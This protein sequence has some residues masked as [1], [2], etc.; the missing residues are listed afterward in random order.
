M[1]T[2]NMTHAATMGL[3]SSAREITRQIV[4]T[5]HS[6]TPGGGVR[7]LEAQVRITEAGLFTF[8][9][10]LSADIARLRVP[11]EQPHGGSPVDGIT[12]RTDGLWRHT[13]F[14][15]F[16]GLGATAQYVE[17]N[18][19]PARQWAAYCFD[20]Y[21]TGMAPLH[22][23]HPPALSVRRTQQRLE[24]DAVVQVPHFAGPQPAAPAKLAVAAVIEGDNGTLSYWAARHP[25]GP[26][27][28]HHPHGFAL[29]I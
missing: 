14:E 8:K 27:D 2:L 20:A 15:A 4:L 10:S 22:L 23:A 21:R 5:A 7:S 9:Y 11:E 17:L 28:F 25:P 13:C 19:S 18:F 24:L 1:P 16:I 12:A 6:S 29:E 3:M 26:P